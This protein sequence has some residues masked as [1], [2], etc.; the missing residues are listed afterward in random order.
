MY[1]SIDDIRKN[2]PDISLIE[3]TDDNGTGQIENTIV[4]EAI[5]Y[6]D[7]TID[8]YLRGRYS[9]PLN[10]VP[11]II[12]KIS[13]DIAIYHIYSRRFELEMPE[14]MQKRYENA[15]KLLEAIRKGTIELGITT[16]TGQTGTG[17]YITNKVEE[18]RI[19]NKNFLDKL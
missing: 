11:K 5:A 19:F 14:G 10:P 9:L 6:A 4:S 17:Y 8:G 3:L 12:Q 1:C 18:D 13:I 7:S 2:I 16:Q 15:V